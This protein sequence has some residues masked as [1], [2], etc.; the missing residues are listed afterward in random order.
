MKGP[1]TNDRIIS[2]IAIATAPAASPP[3]NEVVVEMLPV[4]SITNID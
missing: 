2:D 1:P 4:F 3:T